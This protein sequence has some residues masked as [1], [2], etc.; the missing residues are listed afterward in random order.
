MEITNKTKKPLRVP[1]PAGKKLFL[2]PGK[3]GQITPAAAARPA[4][5]KLLE[6]GDIE[7][8]KGGAKRQGSGS[9]G[10]TVTDVSRDGRSGAMRQSG[11]K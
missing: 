4:V 2:N 7:I 9:S 8:S 1:L 5:V 11:D 6:A 3:S 10:S